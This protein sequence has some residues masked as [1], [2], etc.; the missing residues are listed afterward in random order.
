M[1]DLT[2]QQWGAVALGVAAVGSFAYSHFAELKAFFGKIVPTADTSD[3]RLEALRNL[4]EVYGYFKS[5]KCQE[6]MDGVR[7]LVPHIFD[8][9]HAEVHP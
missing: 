3:D 1:P 8:E 7:K 6:G 5:V 4:D 2:P 9:H